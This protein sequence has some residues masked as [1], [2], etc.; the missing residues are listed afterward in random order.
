MN[1]QEREDLYACIN[2]TM[3]IAQ[4]KAAFPGPAFAAPLKGKKHDYVQFAVENYAAMPQNNRTIIN[5]ELQVRRQEREAEEARAAEENAEAVNRAA[6]NAEGDN[7]GA[8]RPKA[9]N[10]GDRAPGMAEGMAALMTGMREIRETLAGIQGEVR[11]L[12]VRVDEGQG[13]G[14]QMGADGGAVMGAAGFAA[15]VRGKE[16]SCLEPIGDQYA[17]VRPASVLTDALAG[18]FSVDKLY[19]LLDPNSLLKVAP[20]K[21]KASN[22]SWTT[23]GGFAVQETEETREEMVTK[24]LKSFPTIEY[25]CYAWMNLCAITIHTMD[26]PTS[27]SDTVRAFVWHQNF[28]IEYHGSY[29]WPGLLRYHAAVA[30]DRYSSGAFVPARWYKKKD[31]IRFDQTA[32]AT[33]SGTGSGLPGYQAATQ[34][35]MK[36]WNG[37]CDLP[38]N[39]C[40]RPHLCGKCKVRHN[41]FAC[42]LQRRQIGYA[43]QNGYSTYNVRP[44]P[45]G[46][47][48]VNL[49]PVGPRPHQIPQA[50]PSGTQG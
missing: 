12:Q 46:L 40:P 39:A 27:I 29:K 4:L 1:D 45:P 22:V 10:G 44:P 26:D 6:A 35:C 24:L 17:F 48:A 50:G 47:S 28:L 49:G 8:A 32:R 23:E 16:D 15:P 11:T 42:P 9:Q 36:F 31:N 2:K 38:N 41:K 25:F 21:E 37:Q 19:A 34:N 3:K 30:T 5:A 33:A 13:A 43:P 7:G 14:V 20:V 18:R